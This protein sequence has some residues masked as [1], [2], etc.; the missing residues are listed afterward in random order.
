L[1]ELLVVIAIIGIL[2][3]LLL[4]AVQAA[5]EAARRMQCAN[6]LKQIGLAVHAYHVARGQFPAGN[7]LKQA[8]Y[9]P[10]ETPNVRLD[11][12]ANWLLAIL[13]YVEENPLADQYDFDAYNEA[14]INRQA[15]ETFVPIYACPS[16]LEPDQVSVPAVGPASA[17]LLNLPYMP[18][19]YRA[20]SGR[21]D[22][23]RFLD[24]SE[25]TSYASSWRGPIHAVG[26]YGFQNERIRDVR[27]GLSQTLLAGESTTR[28]NRPWRTFW[29]YSY[30]Y[31]SVSA[32][33]PQNRIL[34][35]DYDAC[36][37]AG[38]TGHDL[39]CKRGWGG[40]HA[41]G[42]HFLCCDGSVHFID[43]SIDM[44]LLAQLAT[45][46]GEEVIEPPW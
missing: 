36:L 23:W 21:S 15:R 5:R 3:A 40:F 29:A 6:N 30:A 38:G 18:G 11:S 22:G 34:L 8:G 10:G 41:G 46:D 25:L 44:E 42:L 9:C 33:A 16:D 39:P 4:P 12:G 28:T 37:A 35:G 31:F 26:V 2:V 32:V 20:V 17:Y 43:S 7:V 13:P 45:I 19:S 1:V 14:A 24:S 27:D